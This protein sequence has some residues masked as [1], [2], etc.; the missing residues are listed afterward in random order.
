[1][2]SHT[3]ISAVARRLIEELQ[4]ERQKSKHLVVCF[5]P[6]MDVLLLFRSRSGKYPTRK[7]RG[8]Q[9]RSRRVQ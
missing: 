1:M 9:G 5:F 2:D 8:Y 3:G 4:D 6:R 7:A